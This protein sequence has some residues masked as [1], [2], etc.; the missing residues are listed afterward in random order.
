ML[1][2]LVCPALGAGAMLYLKGYPLTGDGL[3]KLGY[4]MFAEFVWAS[5]GGLV[6][7]GGGLSSIMMSQRI[8]GMRVE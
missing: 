1:Q 3:T 5:I 8:L 6:G 7:F 2:W 4:G